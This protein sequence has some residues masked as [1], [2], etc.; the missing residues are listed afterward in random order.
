MSASTARS[1]W[2]DPFLLPVCECSGPMNLASLEP[3][4]TRPDHELKTY[5]CTLCSRQQVFT[6]R[7]RQASAPE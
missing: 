6:A 4:P 2:R 1:A 3:H 7:R 5:K